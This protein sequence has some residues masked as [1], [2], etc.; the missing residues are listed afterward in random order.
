[1]LP[2]L[3]YNNKASK[4]E[5][6]KTFRVGNNEVQTD[7]LIHNIQLGAMRFIESRN[8]PDEEKNALGDAYIDIMNRIEK[9]DGTLYLDNENRLVDTTGSIQE[10]QYRSY[11]KILGYIIPIMKSTKTYEKK[12]DKKEFSIKQFTKDLSKHLGIDDETQLANF[13][14][15]DQPDENGQRGQTNRI[16]K[17]LEIITDLDNDYK[18]EYSDYNSENILKIRDLLKDGNLSKTEQFDLGIATGIPELYN[19]FTTETSKQNQTPQQQFYEWINAHYPYEQVD[20]QIEYSFKDIQQ[21]DDLESDLNS[22]NTFNAD[23]INTYL[24]TLYNKPQTD[25]N[26]ENQRKA[27]ITASLERLLNLNQLIKISDNQYVIP[28]LLEGT[29]VMVWDRENNTLKQYSTHDLDYY[30]Q[31]YLQE[32]LQ[33]N[34]SVDNNLFNR[35]DK[36]FTKYTSSHKKGGILKAQ[37]GTKLDIW[38]AVFYTDNDLNT[39]YRHIYSDNNLSLT[40]RGDNAAKNT[41]YLNDNQYD[42]ELGGTQVENQSWWNN[43]INTLKTNEQLAKHWAK[44]YKGL[45]TVTNHANG[46]FDANGNFNYDEFKKSKVFNDKINGIGHDIYRG[47]VYQIE[48]QDGYL[49]QIPEG[50]KLKTETPTQL[51]DGTPID[52][53]TLIKSDGVVPSDDEDVSKQNSKVTPEGDGESGIS[54]TDTDP[55]KWNYP[56]YEPENDS[57]SLYPYLSDISRFLIGMGY[58]DKIE[59]L[60]K[61]SIPLTLKNPYELYSPVTGA[62]GEMN[63]YKQ[64]AAALRRRAQELYTAD[65]EKNAAIWAE[66]NKAALQLEQQ[67]FVADNK[68]IKR[69]QSEALGRQEKNTVLRNQ[70]AN[71][72]QEQ[73]DKFN[74]TMKEIE[75]A[76]LQKNWASL[77]TLLSDLET[78]FTTYLSERNA[79]KEENRVAKNTVAKNTSIMTAK[80][81][82]QNA[83][84]SADQYKEMRGNEWDERDIK[85]YNLYKQQARKIYEA[86]AALANYISLGMDESQ[87]S[88]LKKV[89]EM[90]LQD[91]ITFYKERKAQYRRLGGVLQTVKS[92]KRK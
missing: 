27:I 2:F 29:K 85:I 71:Y 24:K 4:E 35:Y 7:E 67:G 60:T 18:T 53:Y 90:Q 64:Q 33:N 70:I 50:Y 25:P 86:R 32:F 52:I 13:I 12:N 15:L 39:R 81:D 87:L 80:D 51:E 31:Q 75:T 61:E 3:I 21:Y 59:D 45:N 84:N 92:L 83:I 57:F 63:M 55:L 23:T 49:S 91:F 79:K 43:W 42:P 1:M 89:A 6:I 58:N 46:W 48:G 20:D 10:N 37:N 56:D 9:G 69:T 74:A 40:N 5:E 30:Q 16:A 34:S 72:N 65:P 78:R 44:G 62:F 47:R 54:V 38:D 8:M 28:A 82:Y 22:I 77:N 36:Y 17:F 68:E 76:H 14:E 73:I 66:Y 19:I 41:K 11:G 88:E 26:V